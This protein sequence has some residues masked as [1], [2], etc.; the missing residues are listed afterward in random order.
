[1]KLLRIKFLGELDDGFAYNFKRFG[2]NPVARFQIIEVTLFHR[3]T[4]RR[5]IDDALSEIGNRKRMSHVQNRTR[6]AVVTS[7][8]SLFT[9]HLPRACRAVALAKA[10]G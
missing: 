1:M 3:K 9:R 7:H 4:L 6:A 5:H 8:L 10:G 2:L